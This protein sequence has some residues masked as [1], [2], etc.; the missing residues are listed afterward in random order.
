MRSGFHRTLITWPMTTRYA[1]LSNEMQLQSLEYLRWCRDLLLVFARYGSS[2]TRAVLSNL[3]M[4]TQLRDGVWNQSVIFE[5]WLERIRRQQRDPALLEVEGWLPTVQE[6]DDAMDG[7]AARAHPTDA[8][9]IEAGRNERT[10]LLSLDGVS[11]PRRDRVELDSDYGIV[12]NLSIYGEEF[13][14]AFPRNDPT[15]TDAELG[16][17]QDLVFSLEGRFPL[18][19]RLAS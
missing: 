11:D 4:T 14:A 5:E 2:R 19:P 7:G 15:T 10:R 12:H 16:R 6:T 18:M 8:N 3:E 13:Q 1:S 17:Q 9:L